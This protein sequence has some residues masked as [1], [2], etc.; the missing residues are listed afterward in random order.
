MDKASGIYTQRN[1]FLRLFLCQSLI[2]VIL[3][4]LSFY[5]FFSYHYKVITQNQLESLDR[6]TR[7]IADQIKV[8]NIS[9]LEDYSQKYLF[10]IID[11]KS[12]VYLYENK[13]REKN[14]IQQWQRDKEKIISEMIAKKNGLLSY[15]LESSSVKHLIQYRFINEIGWIIGSEIEISSLGFGNLRTFFS[16][17]FIIKIFCLI[18]VGLF[19][20][21]FSLKFF[22][23]NFDMLQKSQLT[24]NFKES[25]AIP[26]PTSIHQENFHSQEEQNVS[27]PFNERPAAFVSPIEIVESYFP[28]SD[29][30]PQ[31]HDSK[32]VDEEQKVCFEEN[33][34]N[35]TD[36]LFQKTKETIIGKAFLKNKSKK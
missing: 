16:L 22:L 15:P 11:Q 26:L 33:N 21:F 3:I 1:I 4:G 29:S 9:P 10:F 20:L 18:C 19:L 34:K 25:D 2:L 8:V 17:D 30:L 6:M 7:F 35:E 27:Q 23:F 24:E 13:P 28:N 36:L 5:Y 12:G 14:F 32:I 31:M